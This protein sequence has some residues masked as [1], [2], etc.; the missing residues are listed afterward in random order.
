LANDIAVLMLTLVIPRSTIDQ[1]TLKHVTV[2]AS[3]LRLVLETEIK[4]EY[5]F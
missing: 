5:M 1:T 4:D 2:Q 3:D